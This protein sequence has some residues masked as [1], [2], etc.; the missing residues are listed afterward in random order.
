MKYGDY[1]YSQKPK[2][3]FYH[4]L[5][6]FIIIKDATLRLWNSDTRKLEGKYFFGE[7]ISNINIKDMENCYK[8]RSVAINQDEDLILVGFHN[9]D[10][11]S[12]TLE[13]NK[14]K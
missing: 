10:V 11:R 12:F 4:V 8:A 3:Y 13:N 1:A 7:G 14:I 6:V 2:I 5:M 9:G